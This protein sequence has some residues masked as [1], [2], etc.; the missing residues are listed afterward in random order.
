MKAAR[1]ERA[2]AAKERELLQGKPYRPHAHNFM[3][4]DPRVLAEREQ[5]LQAL[6]VTE[7][8]VNQVLLGDPLPGRSALDGKVSNELS[9]TSRVRSRTDDGGDAA[10]AGD[11]VLLDLLRE[12]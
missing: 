4:P 2:R 3:R 5:R 7:L 10:A 9:Q 6:F 12:V 11:V 8:T 1:A